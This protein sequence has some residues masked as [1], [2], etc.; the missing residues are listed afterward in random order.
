MFSSNFNHLSAI[1]ALIPG[2]FFSLPTITKLESIFGLDL[3]RRERFGDFK[4]FVPKQITSSVHE[5]FVEFKML[6]EILLWG[7]NRENFQFLLDAII[8]CFPSPM[9]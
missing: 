4:L 5:F 9:K 6:R 2:S 7:L 8:T 3:K 1:I